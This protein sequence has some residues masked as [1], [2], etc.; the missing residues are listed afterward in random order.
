MA[1][2]FILQSGKYAGQELSTVYA[3]Q[4]D[5]I[6]GYIW[7]KCNEKNR[8]KLYAALSETIPLGDIKAKGLAKR[9]TYKVKLE[10]VDALLKA[11]DD[12]KIWFSDLESFLSPGFEDTYQDILQDLKSGDLTEDEALELFSDHLVN[13]KKMCEKYRDIWKK[14]V[15]SKTFITF[16]EAKEL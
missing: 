7:P 12:E 1:S 2:E 8:P 3:G 10:G 9:R 11:I 15:L 4:P 6:M 16:A 5:Y 13:E 14:V